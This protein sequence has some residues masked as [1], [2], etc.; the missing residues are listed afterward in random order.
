MNN[1][2]LEQLLRQ[3][4]ERF[5]TVSTGN[6]DRLAGNAV[7]VDAVRCRRHRQARRRTT[8]GVLAVFLFAGVISTWSLSGSF[9]GGTDQTLNSMAASPMRQPTD[10]PGDIADQVPPPGRR[11]SEDEI[12][13]LKAEIAALDAEANRARQ[14]VELYRAAESRRERLAAAKTALNEPLLPPQVLAELQIDRAAA[15]TVLSADLQ[16][17]AFD[18]RD[19]AT[20]AYQSVLKHFPNS[21]WA[22]IA[23]QRLAQV[24]H[25]N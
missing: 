8:L 9:N 21:R 15:I 2:D 18:R 14:F 10:L 22:N 23:K 24:Q 13:R 7:F 25:M 1:Y 3:A 20:D 4:D 19:E 17:N 11:L 5:C 12:T 16:A 6:A